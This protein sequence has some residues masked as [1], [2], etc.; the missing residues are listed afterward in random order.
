M[1]PVERLI[2]DASQPSQSSKQTTERIQALAEISKKIP[3]II[4]HAGIA[5]SALTRKDLPAGSNGG[6]ETGP[7][8]ANKVVFQQNYA[9][10]LRLLAE[11]NG[12]L[13]D[14]AN[15][16]VDA[17]LMPEKAPKKGSTAD[18]VT[19]EGMGNIDVGYL[20]SRTRDVGAVKE[21][22]LVGEMKGMLEKLIEEQEKR[23]HGKTGGAGKVDAMDET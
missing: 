16:M 11:V 5:V 6:D 23:I 15:H 7:L 4:E 22:E 12:A 10:F 21:R 3:K 14:E 17:K 19:N 13:N 8:A 9:E 20:N 18:G 2:N 1:D